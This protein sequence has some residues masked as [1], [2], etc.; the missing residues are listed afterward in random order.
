MLA[1]GNG[2]PLVCALNLV[3]TVRGEVPYERVKGISRE[4]IDSPASHSREQFMSDTQWLIETYEPRL[5]VDDID[6]KSMEA[7][8]GTF[9]YDTLVKEARTK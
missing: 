5:D 1:H 7:M 8:T 2:D 9:D 3:R 4:L 6:I